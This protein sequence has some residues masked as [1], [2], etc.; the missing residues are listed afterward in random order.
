M[1]STW[2]AAIAIAFAGVSAVAN[3][4]PSEPSFAGEYIMRGKGFGASDRPYEGTCSIMPDERAY[5][6]SCFNQDTRH[7]YVGKGLALGETLAMFIG[8]HLKGDHNSVFEGQYLVV[9]RREPNG[10]LVGTWVQAGT[11]ASGAETLTP[12]Q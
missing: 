12:K 1:K 10:R 9:Y 6:V 7:T 2:I 5:R 8:D 3:A 11:A 4:Q